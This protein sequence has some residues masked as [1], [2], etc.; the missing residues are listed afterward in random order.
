M[1]LNTRA[2]RL[3]MMRIWIGFLTALA[4][5]LASAV[6]GLAET[7]TTSATL[8]LK[9]SEEAAPS[10]ATLSRNDMKWHVISSGGENDAESA[11]FRL[12][13][14]VAQTAAGAADSPNF[15]L[16]HGFWQLF[17][18]GIDCV[19]GDADGSG[20]VDVDD[21]VY[22]VAFIFSGGPPPIPDICCGDADG[23]GG[24]DIDDVVY[25]IDYIFSGGP[26]PVDAC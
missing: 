6:A 13:G 23:S 16:D 24:V 9:A 5:V 7:S 10:A 2:G 18:A 4:L 20:A 15:T 21:I 11:H 22:L 14:T 8:Q 25:L 1:A 17:E 19:P 12:S 3:K 26:P